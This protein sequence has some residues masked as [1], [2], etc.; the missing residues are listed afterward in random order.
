MG[1]FGACGVG[2]DKQTELFAALAG[3]LHIGNITFDGDEVRAPR[4]LPLARRLPSRSL[5]ALGSK[6]RRLA[7]ARASL[8]G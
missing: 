3:I 6:E 1:A 4:R 7:R 8:R 5:L 2:G